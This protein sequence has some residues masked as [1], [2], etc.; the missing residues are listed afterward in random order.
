MEEGGELVAVEFAESYTQRELVRHPPPPPPPRPPTLL[1]DLPACELL[2][3]RSAS[4]AGARVSGALLVGSTRSAKRA[5][6]EL[7]FCVLNKP[8]LFR[9][10]DY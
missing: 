8:K 1:V 7:P 9:K 4:G 10:F 6:Q 3:A 2:V 5:V